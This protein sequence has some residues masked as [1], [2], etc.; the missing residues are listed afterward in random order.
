MQFLTLAGI[1]FFVMATYPRGYNHNHY[2]KIIN[3]SEHN[4]TRVVV[5]HKDTGKIVANEQ[6]HELIAKRGGA[7][8]FELGKGIWNYIACVEAEDTSEPICTIPLKSNYEGS[9]DIT[10]NGSNSSDWVPATLLPRCPKL[11]SQCNSEIKD[12]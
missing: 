10:W 12:E 8:T 6:D 2:V 1:I 4:I 7:K 3:K 9:I 11:F 5:I